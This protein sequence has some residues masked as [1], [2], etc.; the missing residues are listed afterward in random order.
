M[1]TKRLIT[2][3]LIQL[4]SYFPVVG[5]TGS[6]Q[7]GKT[8][9]IKMLSID[10]EV[11]YLDLEKPED[12]SKLS[13]PSLFLKKLEDKCVILDEIQRAPHLFPVLRSLIDENR[14]PARFI[15]SGSA[16][17]DL[18]RDSSE[19]LAGR[20]AYKELTPFNLVEIIDQ[21][22]LERHWLRGGYILSLIAPTAL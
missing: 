5:I 15:I 17:P 12:L 19:S 3:D 16:S 22:D 11:V 7:V 1:L 18:I 20:I 9:L 10:K 2:E 13:E 4:L 14:V 6:R 21:A 8:T